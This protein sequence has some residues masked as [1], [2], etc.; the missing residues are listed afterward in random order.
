MLTSF[1]FV[2]GVSD[3]MGDLKVTCFSSLMLV[4]ISMTA[5]EGALFGTFN[6]MSPRH[7]DVEYERRV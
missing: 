1:F 4:M 2:M 7:T 3:C 6:W 5:V